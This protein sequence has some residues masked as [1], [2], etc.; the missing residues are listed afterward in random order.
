[1][2][3]MPGARH[4]STHGLSLTD[5]RSGPPIEAVSIDSSNLVRRL[6]NFYSFD[7]C[8]Q[9]AHAGRCRRSS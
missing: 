1:M 9:C 4:P 7:R 2:T 5:D 3:A 6:G 8:E